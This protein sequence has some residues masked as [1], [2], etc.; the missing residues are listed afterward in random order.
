MQHYVP[1][2]YLRRFV[3]QDGFLWAYDKD[4]DRIFPSNPR[5][6]AGERAF[7]DLPKPFPDPSEME[8]QFSEM[9]RDAA[10]ITDEW[11][12]QVVPGELI[13]IPSEHREIMSLFITTQL[14]R[15]SEARTQLVQGSERSEITSSDE[16]LQRAF[17]I[18]MLWNEEFI[19]SYSGWVHDC[20]WAF[21]VNTL[22]ESLFTSDDPIKVR[23]STEHL[24]WGQAL[25]EGAYLLYPLTPRC[26]MYCFDPRKWDT[27]RPFDCRVSPNPL[28]PELVRDANIHQ[29]GHARRFVFAECN[30]FRVAQDF[31]VKNPGAVGQSRDRFI[32]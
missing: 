18:G 16:E 5:N 14:I 13:D 8:R 26:L 10:S 1:Q 7:Y 27:I 29:V 17:H 2:F 19:D 21:R 3:G 12:C 30:D 28:E 24:H 25:R 31:C 23:T 6:L 22:S 9:E 11:L 4:K 15:T 32:P 20:V